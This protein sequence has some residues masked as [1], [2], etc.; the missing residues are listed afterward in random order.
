MYEY[1]P[2]SGNTYFYLWQ[3]LADR[4][5]V[6]IMGGIN[7]NYRSAFGYSIALQHTEAH[8]FPALS[9]L[10]RQ[11]GSST[12]KEAE[13]ASE[14]FVDPTEYIAPYAERELRCNAVQQF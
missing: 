10:G 2:I 5:K 13:V 1:L 14:A 9:N 4:L 7:G 11:I 3:W 12:D 8:L 6:V